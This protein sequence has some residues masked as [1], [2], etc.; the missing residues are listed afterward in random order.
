MCHVKLP[1]ELIVKDSKSA[2][3][4]GI[5]NILLALRISNLCVYKCSRRGNQTFRSRRRNFQ[6]FRWMPKKAHRHRHKSIFLFDSRLCAIR[7]LTWDIDFYSFSISLS[8]SVN[9][10]LNFIS[11]C[12]CCMRAEKGTATIKCHWGHL[13]RVVVVSRNFSS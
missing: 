11:L 9:C 7:S 12:C 6:R 8:C 4:R 13:S 5:H 3:Y 10:E 1:L 2:R